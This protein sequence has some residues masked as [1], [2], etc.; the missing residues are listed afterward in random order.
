MNSTPKLFTVPGTKMFTS[1][2]PANISHPY[3]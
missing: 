2:E 1:I 3:G